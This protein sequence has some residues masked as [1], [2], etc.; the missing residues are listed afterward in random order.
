MTGITDSR[1]SRTTSFFSFPTFASAI[2]CSPKHYAPASSS[3][4]STGSHQPRFVSPSG[5]PS[6]KTRRRKRSWERKIWGVRNAGMRLINCSVA[7]ELWRKWKRSTLQI[8]TVF[9]C[10]PAG[11]GAKAKSTEVRFS[12]KEAYF[13]YSKPWLLYKK[14]SIQ[15]VFG[16]L[17]STFSSSVSYFLAKWF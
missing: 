6:L 5:L 11:S 3:S 16:L 9:V 15:E 17:H 12:L 13:V 2:A 8:R 1:S 14:R 10:S 7:D 4:S